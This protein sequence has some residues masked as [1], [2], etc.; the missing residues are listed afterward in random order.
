MIRDHQGSDRSDP[1]APGLSTGSAL[2]YTIQVSLGFGDILRAVP[3]LLA[4]NGPISLLLFDD[5]DDDKRLVV[6]WTRIS[7]LCQLYHVPES[8]PK[9]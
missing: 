7:K 2:G 5:D 3:D 9:L 4:S 1:Y 8:K 6:E